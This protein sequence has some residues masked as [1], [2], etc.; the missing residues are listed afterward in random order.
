ME[1]NYI[2]FSEKADSLEFRMHHN[3]FNEN[4]KTV[5]LKIKIQNIQNVQINDQLNPV[6]NYN[7]KNVH[8]LHK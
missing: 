3:V 1:L 8:Y 5:V 2:Q 4:K 6:Q 7:L